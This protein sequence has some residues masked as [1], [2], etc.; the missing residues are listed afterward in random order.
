MN[1]SRLIPRLDLRRSPR[2]FAERRT[3][4]ILER[5]E[6]VRLHRPVADVDARLQAVTL[7]QLRAEA[8]T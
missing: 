3:E 2:R 4:L 1:L 7:A 5:R 6:R 8:R